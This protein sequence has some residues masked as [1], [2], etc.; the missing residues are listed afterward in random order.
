MSKKLLLQILIISFIVGAFGSIFFDRVVLPPLS[1]FPGLSW[2]SRL[3]SDTPIVITR[4]E[5]VRL[6]EGVNLIELTKQA[7]GFTVSIFNVSESSTELLGSG[8]ILSSDGLIFTA[9]AVVGSQSEVTVVLNDGSNYPGLVRALDPNSE[10]AVVT[11]PTNNLPIAQFEKVAD[12]VV[13][14]RVLALGKTTEPF[15]RKFASG[16]VTKTVFNNPDPNKVF[17]SDFLGSTI[18]TDAPLSNDF[19]GGPVFNLNGRVV[20][21]VADTGGKILISESLDPALKT[22]LAEG[23]IV[24]PKLGLNYINITDSLAKL[25]GLNFGGARVVQIQRGGAASLAGLK[26]NDVVVE[27]EGQSVVEKNFEFV[28]NSNLSE[29]MRFVILRDNEREEIIVNPVI[30]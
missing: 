10:L 2:L 7:Q 3:R 1:T 30:E 23:K 13:A 8:I 12:L 9:K 15:T 26:V 27:I 6:N 22:Y 5:E 16:F 14:Q 29:N 24:R 21:M 11:I 4:K 28:F 18:L 17:S 25:L 19:A 20:G